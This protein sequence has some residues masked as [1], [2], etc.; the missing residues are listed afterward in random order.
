MMR[1][2]QQIRNR[3]K[4]NYKVNGFT[5]TEL[6]VVM[7]LTSIVITIGYLGI[8]NVR[9]FILNKKTSSEELSEFRM[10][11]TVMT[12]DISSSYE[13]KYD[14]I[15]QTIKIK[16]R[17]IE[18]QYDSLYWIR[19]SINRIDTFH[20]KSSKPTISEQ[21]KDNRYIKR[22]TFYIIFE[23]DSAICSFYRE[24]PIMVNKIID[25]GS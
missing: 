6:I 21:E 18:Y 14:D 13:F 16:D 23:G 4:P 7:L 20:I 22:L 2:L 17:E 10:L 9:R 25:N 1:N 8:T 15:D 11:K 12:K 24:V 19:S 3:I 5:L